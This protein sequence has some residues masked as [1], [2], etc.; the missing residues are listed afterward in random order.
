M[1][2]D[3]HLAA[4]RRAGDAGDAELADATRL[5]VRRSLDARSKTRRRM[6]SGAAALGVLL[7]ATASWALA[8][9]QLQELL[10]RPSAPVP[11]PV[12]VPAPVPVPVP[13]PDL[14][15]VPT[16]T[17]APILVPAPPVV[18]QKDHP[19]PVPIVKPIVHL[20]T[21]PAPVVVIE[22]P[23]VVDTIAQL[24]RHAHELHFHASDPAAALAAWDAYLAAAP[25]ARFSVEARYNRAICL[26]KLGRLAEARSA[27][28]PFAEDR[29]SP[30]GYR[31][32][33]ARALLQRID[34]SLNETRSSGDDRP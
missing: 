6:A 17:P 33:D 16:P 31:A 24:Y 10:H 11:V 3:D 23:R 28:A 32:D 12:P 2:L 8:T 5:R 22:E 9:G 13:V 7:C 26:V 4:L 21:P 14:L 25:D 20:E 29:V 15:P 19:A 30:A 34:A 27:L 18:L 1:S